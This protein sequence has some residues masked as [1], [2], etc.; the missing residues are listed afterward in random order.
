MNIADAE[1]ISTS[2]AQISSIEGDILVIEG[3][4]LGDWLPP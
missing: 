4:I 3:D 2:E 1:E